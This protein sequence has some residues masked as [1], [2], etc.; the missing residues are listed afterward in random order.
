MLLT[1]PFDVGACVCPSTGL[2]VLICMFLWPL[3]GH[4]AV[5]SQLVLGADVQIEEIAIALLCL[6][7]F[8]LV[9]VVR[10]DVSSHAVMLNA[11]GKC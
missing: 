10:L 7:S 1:L 4:C 3:P 2:L 8:C 6:A 11:A 9:I 5:V